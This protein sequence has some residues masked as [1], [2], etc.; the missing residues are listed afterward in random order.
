MIQGQMISTW[1]MSWD[2]M[3]EAACLLSQ[4]KPIHEA[5][6]T[7]VKSVEDNPRFVSVGY[8]G[9]PN[10]QGEVQ[11]DAAYMDGD[12]LGFGGIIEVSDIQNPIEV[13]Y[14]LSKYQRNC[15]LSGE[16]AGLYA[17]QNGFAIR[18]MLTPAAKERYLAQKD[19]QVDMELLEAYDGHDTVCVLG[20]DPNTGNISCGVSTSGLFLKHPGRVGDSPIIGSGFYADSL[21]GAAGCTGVGEDIM[22]GCLSFAIVEKMRGGMDPQTACETAVSA[23]VQRMSQKGHQVSDI[24]AIAIAPDGTVGAATNIPLFPFVVVQGDEANLYVASC[25]EGKVSVMEATEEW[26]QGYTG[27]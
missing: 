14:D 13:A 9:L 23:H 26:L 21:A 12:T 20:K 2:G 10:I 5:I 19:K 24:S 11:L 8:G 1:K 15:L 22:K 17:R 4:G 6:L 16:G 27:D 3:K 18:N 25:R 7:A